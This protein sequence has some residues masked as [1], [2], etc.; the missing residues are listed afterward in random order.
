MKMISEL[1]DHEHVE[2]QFLVGNVS[3]GVNA[4]GGSYF[5]V[6]LRDASGNIAAKK[7]DATLQDEQIFV[8]GN[9]IAVTGETNK[10]KEQLQLK[11]LT[12]E[13]V[14]LEEID[15]ERFVK[16][17]PVAKSE[18][19][20]RF[21]DHMASVKNEDCQKLLKYFVNKFGDNIFSYPAA[22]SIHHGGMKWRSFI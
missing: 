10:Y 18:L 20:K 22:V 7:W 5:S 1:T 13:L 3:K 9:V 21:N 4:V 11:V 14:P 19:I 12:A 6:E 16:A 8:A 2:G 15:V 17:P